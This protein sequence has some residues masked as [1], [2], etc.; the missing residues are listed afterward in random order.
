MLL[1]ALIMI[2]LGVVF[3][4]LCG[5]IIHTLLHSQKIEYL[6]RNHMIH[7]MKVYGPQM[8]QRPSEKYKNSL[9]NRAEI[10]GVGM[11]W[12][13]PI[14]LII[15]LTYGITFYLNI[16]LMWTSLFIVTALVWG[17][18]LFGYM[19]DAMH[20]AN[21]WMSENSIFKNWFLKIRKLHDI[22][23]LHISNDGKMNVNY[24]ICFFVFDRIFRTYQKEH[25][26]FN[27]PGYQTAKDR[28][29]F[30]EEKI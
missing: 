23:H 8:P 4:E 6:S 3:A 25:T 1:Q 11:E 26:L 12:V 28:Y 9:G 24:G 21:F 17:F 10:L 13:F 16:S 18:F 5:Y 14:A 29:Q 27:K 22:H 7:H 2:F 15:L 19:H 30:I 20:V